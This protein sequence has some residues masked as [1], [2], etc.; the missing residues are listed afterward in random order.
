M[1]NS[2]NTE[3]CYPLLYSL[4]YMI[5]AVQTVVLL[6]AFYLTSFDCTVKMMPIKI[7]FQGVQNKVLMALTR[8]LGPQN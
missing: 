2:L 1:R 8:I 6:S 5:Q 7:I 3:P 4:G